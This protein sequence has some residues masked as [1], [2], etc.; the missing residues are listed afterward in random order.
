MKQSTLI[1]LVSL[2]L[3]ES[4]GALCIGL[5]LVRSRLEPKSGTVSNYLPL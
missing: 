1:D 3:S 2:E 4:M 5:G